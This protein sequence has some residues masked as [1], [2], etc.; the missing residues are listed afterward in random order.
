MAYHYKCR[1]CGTD[2]GMLD[3]PVLDSMK[4]GF[5]ALTSQERQEMIS[6]T[7]TGDYQV[8]SICED[9]QEAFEKNPSNHQNDFLIQ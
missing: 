6:I 1:H 9:C 2:I 4:L 7:Q 5:H 8:S 3:E